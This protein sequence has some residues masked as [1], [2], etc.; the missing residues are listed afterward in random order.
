[1]YCPLGG[2]CLSPNMVYQR[3]TTSTQPNY[4]DKVYFRNAEY[5]PIKSVTYED[6]A[7]DTELSTKYWEIKRNNFIPKVMW[8]ILPE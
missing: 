8:S 1:M 3:K 2:K 6:Y 7:N 4:N 5:N